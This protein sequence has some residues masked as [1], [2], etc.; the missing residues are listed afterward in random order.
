MIWTAARLRDISFSD[1]SKLL[2]NQPAKLCGLEDRKGDLS[3]GKDADFVIWDPEKSIKVSS[4]VRCLI[5]SKNTEHCVSIIKKLLYVRRSRQT[6]FI[7]K[8]K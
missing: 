3:V 2:S 8:T 6:T 1:I 5:I 7:T 4:I